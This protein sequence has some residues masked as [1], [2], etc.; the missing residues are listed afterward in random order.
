MDE[1]LNM[2]EDAPET[3]GAAALGGLDPQ[4]QLAALFARYPAMEKQRQAER[5]R[6]KAAK[7]ARFEAARTN[8]E[9]QRFGAPTTSQQ[10][11]ALSQ[12]LLAPRRMRGFAGTLANIM[13]AIT[14]PADLRAAA[15]TKREAALRQLREQYEIDKEDDVIKALEAESAAVRE[16][17]KIL[18]PLAKPP[19]GQGRFAVSANPITGVETYKNF[20]VPVAAVNALLYALQ[21]PGA[22]EQQKADT[23]AAFERKYKVP[24]ATFIEGLR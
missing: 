14:E 23:T 18:G 17:M 10:L 4:A 13:P 22:T 8:I 24:A 6:I 19:S 7:A 20:A 11:A 15:E 2:E 3:E 21:T 1:D 16:Q 5:E 9:Q 12:A